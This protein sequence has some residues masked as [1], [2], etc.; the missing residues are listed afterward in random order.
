M[1]KIKQLLEGKIPPNYILDSY[2][3]A[4]KPFSELWN[5]EGFVWIENKGGDKRL[6]SQRYVLYPEDHESFFRDNI[7]KA[8]RQ[9]P[10]VENKDEIRQ[11]QK[12][13]CNICGAK[14]SPRSHVR[15]T[16]SVEIE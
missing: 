14:I 13:L 7:K 6:G 10:K 4:N 8:H 1:P 12:G 3:D 5:E 15:K 11:S 16:V 2:A 9:A